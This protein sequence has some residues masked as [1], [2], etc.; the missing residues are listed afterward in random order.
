M[1]SSKK[2]GIWILLG[3]FIGLPLI[4]CGGVGVWWFGR[5]A[6]AQAKLDEEIEAL[7]AAGL[8]YDDRSMAQYHSKLTDDFYTAKWIEVTSVVSSEEFGSA[9]KDLPILGNAD[10][11]PPPGQPWGQQAEVE[12]FLTDS[13]G[14]VKLVHEISQSDM[15]VR[16]PIMFDSYNTLLENTQAMRNVARLMKLEHEVALRA[17]D[18]EREYQAIQSLLGTSIAVRGEPIFV[19]QLVSIAMHGIAIDA[20]QKSVRY[21]NMSDEQWKNV[22]ERLKI[23]DNYKDTL[24]QS[25][26]GERAMALPIFQDPTRMAEVSQNATFGARPIDALYYLRIMERMESVEK[27]DLNTL[28]V[29]TE[30]LDQEFSTELTEAN[31]LTKL[32]T[33]LTGLTVPALGAYSSAFVRQVL[34]NRFA[35]LGIAIRRY[36]LQQGKLPESLSDLNEIGIDPGDMQALGGDSFGYSKID[37]SETADA[38]DA[39]ED[40]AVLWG[41]DYGTSGGR[42]SAGQ[43]VPSEPPSI[44][45]EQG[46]SEV[47]QMWIWKFG[48]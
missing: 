37:A 21:G 47:N 29:E 26:A 19:S 32:D 9:S 7:R 20:I 4:L 45:P 15:P 35:K 13:A 17:E 30:R 46:G 34:Q 5:N 8:P 1:A 48:R 33:I 38:T 27:E 22:A 40:G 24:E 44:D 41:Y 2:L 31:F 39:T 14:I 18:G 11:V 43:T 16:F 42:I 25:Y 3:I 6:V 12:Q 28:L 23:F 10:E 36:Q